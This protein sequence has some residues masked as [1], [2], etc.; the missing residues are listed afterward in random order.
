[1]PGICS[2]VQHK[3][4]LRNRWQLGIPAGARGGHVAVADIVQHAFGIALDGIAQTAAAGRFQL[5]ASPG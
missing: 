5:N 4:A 2:L 3:S 1:M